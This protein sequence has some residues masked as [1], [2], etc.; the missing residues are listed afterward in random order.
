MTVDE[1][2]YWITW[3]KVD[4]SMLKVWCCMHLWCCYYDISNKWNTVWQY[5][6]P[7]GN[8]DDG[9]GG[10]EEGGKI[11][12]LVGT[13]WLLWIDSCS[14]ID[15]LQYF[16]CSISQI[17]LV[18]VTVSKADLWRRNQSL[19]QSPGD[20]TS[21]LFSFPRD[22]TTNMTCIS[23]EWMNAFLQ[24]DGMYFSLWLTQICSDWF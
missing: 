1:D 17:N 22:G 11:A 16:S 6:K 15:L 21:V 23:P 9:W 24:S 7:P 10:G 4:E 20:G 13:Q 2:G 14:R 18:V 12:P 8:P 3:M 19:L 5:Q